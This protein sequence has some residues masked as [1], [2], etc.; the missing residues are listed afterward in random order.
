[1]NKILQELKQHAPFTS[2]GALTGIMLFFVFKNLDHKIVHD[3]FYILHPFHVFLSAMATASIY[4]LKTKKFS[5]LF[6]ILIGYIGSIGIATLSDSLVPYI[7]ELMLGLT[8]EMHIGFIE[9]FWRV[10]ISAIS[11]ILVAYFYTKTKFSHFGHVLISTWAS[12]F[13]IIMAM[14]GVISFS[15]YFF[16]FIFL[17]FSVWLPCCLSDI[18]FPVIFAKN[19]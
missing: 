10:N 4:K 16:I 8:P 13:H 17:F 19:D 2:I 11:G 3:I 18:I 9:A 15:I 6:F 12:L 14:T 1:M 5:L 7:G